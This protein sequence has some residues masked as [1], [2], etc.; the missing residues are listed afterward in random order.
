MHTLTPCHQVIIKPNA[1]LPICP[2]PVDVFATRFQPAH[3]ASFTY[4]RSVGFVKRSIPCHVYDAVRQFVKKQ[5]GQPFNGPFKERRQQRIIKPTER[6]IRGNPSDM[7][8]VT[9]TS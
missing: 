4:E 9:A 7:H 2:I 5:F 8:I 1:S 3:Y 6:R